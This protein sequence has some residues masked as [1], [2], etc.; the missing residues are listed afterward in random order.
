MSQRRMPLIVSH[1]GHSQ[2]LPENTLAAFEAALL[3][4]ADGIELDV[5][6]CLTGE[7]VVHHSK[8]VR[9]VGNVRKAS[10]E[11]LRQ[12]PSGSV[13]PLRS[14]LDRLEPTLVNIEIKGSIKRSN[15]EVFEVMEQLVSIAQVY[16]ERHTLVFSTFD[17]RIAAHFAA[18]RSLGSTALIV[19]WRQGINRA[20]KFS[21]YHQIGSIYLSSRRARPRTLRKITQRGL[22]YSLWKSNDQ[23]SLE[24]AAS[25]EAISVITDDVALA[26]GIIGSS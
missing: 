14:V 17:K 25:S 8:H 13:E 20:I 21:L 26:L 10:L 3:L 22:A 7:L 15:E 1:R 11:S 5:W 16:F 19:G 2:I 24:K 18:L 6:E 9:G 23:K 4:G 12:A